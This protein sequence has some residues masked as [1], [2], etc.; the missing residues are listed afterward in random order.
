MRVKRIAGER[1]SNERATMATL[2]QHTL[3]K[4]YVLAVLVRFIVIVATGCFCGFVDTTVRCI[5][6]AG[7][8]CPHNSSEQPR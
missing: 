1:A 6:F 5:D 2:L 7:E 3:P 4:L 8:K